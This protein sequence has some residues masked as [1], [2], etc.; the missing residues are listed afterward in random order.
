M[1]S[2]TS[3]QRTQYNRFVADGARKA[4][5]TV[6]PDKE[7]LQQLFARGDEWQSYLVAGIRQFSSKTPDY[8]VAQSILGKDFITAEEIMVARSD[9]VYSPE[10]IVELA[11]T[12]PSQETLALLKGYGYG[13][14]PQPPQTLS[15]LVIRASK[16]NHFYSKTGGWYEQQ[17]FAIDDLTGT[18]WLAIK[19]TPVN[20][21]T[22]KN[23]GEQNKL[24]T[25]AERVPNVAEM[26]RFITIFFDVRGVRLFENVYVRTSSIDSDGYHV[27]VGYFDAKG[28][29]INY[30][31][32]SRR[33]GSLGLASARKF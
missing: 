3:K 32:V 7:G 26:S 31:W 25:N 24:L 28:L 8:S 14:M 1:N 12:I 22:N 20:G 10:Q 30:N 29:G 9:V 4:L 6:N 5:T 11:A 13:L 17:A 15:L 33:S 2:I 27:G 19:K 23:W 16:P 21:S 18:G